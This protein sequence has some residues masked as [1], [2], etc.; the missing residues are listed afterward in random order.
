MDGIVVETLFQFWEIFEAVTFCRWVH[1]DN[2]MDKAVLVFFSFLG[3]ILKKSGSSFL[4]SDT[5]LEK[6]SIFFFR[7]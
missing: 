6:G 3:L 2:L 4:L 7:I 5:H 1:V